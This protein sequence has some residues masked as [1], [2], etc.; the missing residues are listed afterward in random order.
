MDVEESYFEIP[1]GKANICLE[2]SDVTI[3]AT[4]Y[5]VQFALEAAKELSKQNISVEVIDPRTI[6]PLDKET[7]I[8]SLR[9]THRLVIVNE[10]WKR[11]GVA[12]EISAVVAEEAFELLDK[13][14]M[15]VAAEN[16][17][18]PFCPALENFVLPNT[19]KII[20]AV[21]SIL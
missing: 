19:K 16:V 18:I 10:A 2:G 21:K 20:D 7:I 8:D 3:V 17:P 4:A 12:S 15:R 9:K 11:G 5:M 13:P 14:I 6:V 1:F